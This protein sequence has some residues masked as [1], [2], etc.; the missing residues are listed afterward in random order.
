MIDPAHKEWIDRSTYTELL[1]RWRFAS[2]GDPM[3]EGETG[4][5]YIEVMKRRREEVGPAGAVL[6]SKFVG[7]ETR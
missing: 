4:A 1:A 6:A 2:S 3:F 7:W 5:Y